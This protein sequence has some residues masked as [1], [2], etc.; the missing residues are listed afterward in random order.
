VV[1]IFPAASR[2]ERR[3]TATAA[4]REQAE[5]KPVMAVPAAPRDRRFV[6]FSA[7]PEIEMTVAP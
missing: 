4:L 5:A 3:R 6:V 2:L 1:S 7:L